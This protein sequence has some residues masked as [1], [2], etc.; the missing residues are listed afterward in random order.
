MGQNFRVSFTIP[1]KWNLLPEGKDKSQ[2]LKG[3]TKK[4]ESGLFIPQKKPDDG[5]GFIRRRILPQNATSIV[6]RKKEIN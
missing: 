6:T 2:K 3:T 1:R 4:K 5:R